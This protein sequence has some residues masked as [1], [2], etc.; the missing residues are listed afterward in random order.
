MQSLW[1]LTGGSAKRDSAGIRLASPLPDDG[2]P[3]LATIRVP[4]LVLVDIRASTHTVVVVRRRSSVAV[5]APT[6]D[7]SDTAAQWKFI[8]TIVHCLR[9]GGTPPRPDIR[10]LG[11][12]SYPPMTPNSSP[13]SPMP[14]P[15]ASAAEK[16]LP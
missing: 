9:G 12:T 4:A 10:S 6:E 15:T 8:P 13:E 11:P 16:S 14:L 7:P 2:A 1:L 5:P 3:A